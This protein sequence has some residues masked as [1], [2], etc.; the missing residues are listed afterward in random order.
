MA[1]VKMVHIPYKGGA[2]A[3]T[4]LLAGQVPVGFAPIASM[5]PHVSSGR[6]RALAVSSLERSPQLPNVPTVSEAGLAGFEMSPWFGILA[7][8]GTPSDIIAKLNT[9]LVRIL[10]SPDIGKQLAAQGVEAA[11]STPQQ[12]LAVIKS[13][14]DKWGRVIREAGIKGE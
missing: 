3:T 14:L 12:F 9:E 6:I 13:D 5:L 8:A 10:R 4:D 11:H 1:Q 7:P 2:P